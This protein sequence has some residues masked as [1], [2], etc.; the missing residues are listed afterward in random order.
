MYEQLR[1]FP[2]INSKSVLRVTTFGIQS[3]DK[4]QMSRVIGAG[5]CHFHSDIAYG[6]EKLLRIKLLL[7][8]RTINPVGK[9]VWEK[10]GEEG[11]YEVGVEFILISKEDH[12]ELSSFVS[13]GQLQFAYSQDGST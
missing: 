10:E 11:G 2:R 5:G 1:R 9:V 12:E 4:I 8:T 7:N 13:S 3:E 6:V